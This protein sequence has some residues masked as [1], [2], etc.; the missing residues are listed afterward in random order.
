MQYLLQTELCKLAFNV[1]F[2]LSS[3][4]LVR[5]NLLERFFAQRLISIKLTSGALLTS[6]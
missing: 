3:E 2:F 1:F 5:M 6:C 4:V